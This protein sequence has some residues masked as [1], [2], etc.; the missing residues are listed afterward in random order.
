MNFELL[1]HCKKEINDLLA[2]GLIRKSQSPWSCSAFYVNKNAEIERGVPRLVINY[3]PLNKA[4]QWIRYPLPN[5][6]D[7][8]QNLCKAKVFSK[9]DL[10]YGFWQIQIK[11]KDRYKTAFTVPFGHYEWN[12]MPFGLKN[13]PSEFQKVMNDTFNPYT[14]FLTVI[15]TMS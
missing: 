9:F 8:F 6:K 13:A 14:T 4:L 15:L 5:K 10:K 12:V 1:E 2:K 3:K 7:L 11:E